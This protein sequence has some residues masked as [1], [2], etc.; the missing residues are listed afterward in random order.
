MET[1]AVPLPVAQGGFPEFS[2]GASIEAGV[3]KSDVATGMPKS[4]RKILD[5]RGCILPNRHYDSPSR[6]NR[7]RGE[8]AF[9]PIL[10]KSVSLAPKISGGTKNGKIPGFGLHTG[11]TD[12]RIE[13]VGCNSDAG[14]RRSLKTCPT[15]QPSVGFCPMRR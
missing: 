8:L 10:D 14:N 5:F 6:L 12:T 3:N 13:Q 9:L 7:R 2:G 1:A 11:G 4:P 15:V